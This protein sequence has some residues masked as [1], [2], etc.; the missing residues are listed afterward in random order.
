[1]LEQQNSIFGILYLFQNSISM[2]HMSV[3]SSSPEN[4]N[5][6]N[7]QSILCYLSLQSPT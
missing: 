6:S 1:V 3:H 2:V 5:R 7:S 4:R